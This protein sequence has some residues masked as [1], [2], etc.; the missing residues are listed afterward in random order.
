MN[1][2]TPTTLFQITFCSRLVQVRT[3]HFVTS[4]VLFFVPVDH[5][6]RDCHV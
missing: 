3:Y 1:R 5:G 6:S 2:S 4:P